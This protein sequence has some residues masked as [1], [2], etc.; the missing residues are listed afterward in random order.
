MAGIASLIIWR[1]KRRLLSKAAPVPLAALDPLESRTLLAATLSAEGVVLVTGT[2]AA[3][4]FVLRL[5]ASGTDLQV[6]GAGTGIGS[7]RLAAVQSVQVDGGGGD[8]M[9]TID[10]GPGL[11]AGTGAAVPIRFDG[12]LGA[13]SLVVSGAPAGVSVAET[14]TPGAAAGAGTAVS[15][16]G[17]K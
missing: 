10:T 14:I 15:V 2:D 3:D 1:G 6:E 5:S 13:D 11:I 9:L 4:A 16:A 7:F 12:G 17:A 8:D